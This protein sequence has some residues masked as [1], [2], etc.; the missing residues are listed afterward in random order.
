[1]RKNFSGIGGKREA[2]RVYPYRVFICYAHEDR[3]LAGKIADALKEMGL[4]PTWDPH[5]APG[6]PFTDAIKTMI[7]HAHL[8]MPIIT[9]NSQ[10]RPWV[11]Q[12]TGYAMAL[13]VPVLPVAV[14]GLPGEMI[15][16][17]QAITIPACA[18]VGLIKSSL[19]TSNL[20]RL[21]S[22]APSP[23]LAM[24]ETAE[25]PEQRTDKMAKY[26]RRVLD[27]A[28]PV[29][30]RQRGALSSWCIPDADVTDSIW[31]RRDGAIK[32]SPYFHMLQREE[33]KA[34]EAH[35]RGAGC[36]LI[37]DPTIEVPT[38]IGAR[39]ARLEIL[40]DALSSLRDSKVDI[41]IVTSPVARDGN[42][43]ILGDWFVAESLV[44]GPGGYRQ[45]VFSWHAPTVLTRIRQFDELFE[46]LCKRA[47]AGEEGIVGPDVD[48]VIG[49]IERI[50][51]CLPAEKD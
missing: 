39:R 3:E 47:Q 27:M 2:K 15:A 29:R 44:P 49:Y 35:A 38:D 18:D 25:W 21:V 7:A 31:E 6:T 10:K 26:A 43:T 46:S 37:I 40:R 33:R 11:H 48:A 23:P 36:W 19:E 12:E 34:F 20:E 13:N 16:Q 22:P 9:E 28:G 50:L 42:L 51:A 17:L 1:M 24:V 32:R 41:K 45:T 14:E 8:F 5:I 4:I 30:V